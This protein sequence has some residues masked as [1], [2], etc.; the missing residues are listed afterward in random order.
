MGKKLIIYLDPDDRR[1]TP[2]ELGKHWS[3]LTNF[4][5]EPEKI[6]GTYLATNRKMVNW[7]ELANHC[8]S[9]LDTIAYSDEYDSIYCATC[10]EWRDMTC[11]DPTCE[12]C[13]ARPAKPSDCE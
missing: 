6:G 8:L 3:D 2:K 1:W 11:G 10:D 7:A 12:Y 4:K 9:C 5:D 13:E